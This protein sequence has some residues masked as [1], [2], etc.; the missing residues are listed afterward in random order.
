VKLRNIKGLVMLRDNFYI[1]S[2]APGSGKTTLI[3]ALKEKGYICVDEP[4]RAI[5]AEQKAIDG[6]GLYNKDRKLFLEL[7]LSRMVYQYQQ[8]DRGN[9]PVIFDRGIPDMIGY[10]KLFE[11]DVKSAINASKIYQYN[12][13]VLF[14]PS[15]HEIYTTDD[16]RIMSFTAAHEF[17]NLIRQAYIDCEYNIIDV[18]LAN[19]DERLNFICKMMEK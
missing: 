2:G 13:N 8:F 5:I 4:A 19:I 15:W 6:D 14:L 12:K 1:L 3:H 7:M 9:A 16:D 17:G 11:V 18:P 10:A